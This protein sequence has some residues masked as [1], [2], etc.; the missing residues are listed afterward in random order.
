M[1][2][3]SSQGRAFAVAFPIHSAALRGDMDGLRKIILR[4]EEVNKPLEHSN[5]NLTGTKSIDS[6]LLNH[7]FI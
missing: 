3:G 6:R 2:A 5:F 7:L 4:G 1:C